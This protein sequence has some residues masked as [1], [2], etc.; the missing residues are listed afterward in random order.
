[1][2]TKNGISFENPYQTS[3]PDKIIL[4]D[5]EQERLEEKIAE[6]VLECISSNIDTQNAIKGIKE[7]QSLLAKIE[8]EF[9]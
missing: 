7:F 9:N 2:T 4:L 5:N 1:M 6:K 8:H 3:S